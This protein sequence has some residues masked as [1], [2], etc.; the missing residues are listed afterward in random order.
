MSAAISLSIERFDGWPLATSGFE[1]GKHRVLDTEL[2]KRL[3]FKQPRQ[4]RE[5]IDRYADAGE[6]PRIVQRPTVRRWKL[7]GNFV[8]KPVNEYW[9]T[10]EEALFVTAKSE[11]K[12]ANEIL[13]A[14]I[15]VF[16]KASRQHEIRR[17][18]EV[19]YVA[20]LLLA[21][22]TSDWDLMW[23]AEF[24]QAICR[25]HSIEW[26]GRVQPKFMA[27][28]YERI[29]RKLLGDEVYDLL[30]ARNPEPHFGSN[31]HQ[32]LTPKAREAVSRSIPAI[33]MAAKQSRTKE[34]FWARFDAEY[35]GGMLQLD[36][37]VARR[38][39]RGEA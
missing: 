28:T 29:Y 13:K 39:P 8:E 36:L 19:G 1:D 4:I 12:T 33:T 31:H 37:F 14:V 27:S 26:D 32:W 2:A 17:T 16:V 22:A 10:L 5:L 23:P 24:T 30:K 6:L 35:C 34:E 20:R 21:D 25:L 7:S 9:L 15:A 18:K 11:T 3:G 38:L